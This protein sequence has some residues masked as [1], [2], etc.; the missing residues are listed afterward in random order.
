M[1]RLLFEPFRIGALLLDNR[2]V[3][4]PMYLAYPDPD[5]FVNQLVLDY[6]AE[7]GASGAGMV[8]VE[9]ATVEPR[10][11]CNPRTL[12]TG[13]DSGDDRFLPGLARLA[14]AIKH[15]GAKAVLQIHHAGRFAKRPDSVAPSA[16]KTWGFLPKAMDQTD[17]ERTIAAFSD[18]ARRR[19]VGRV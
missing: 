5:H 4:L 1:T 16:V 8:V 13:D 14:A 6:Y 9:N 11:L 18:G 3:A 19:T 10:G 17:I 12:L 2:V 15:G 7:I